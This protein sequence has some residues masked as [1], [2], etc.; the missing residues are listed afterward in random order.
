ER[1]GGGG[2]GPRIGIDGQRAPE[3]I[4]E[5]RQAV[6]TRPPIRGARTPARRRASRSPGR[7]TRREI[8]PAGGAVAELRGQRFPPGCQLIGSAGD[9][10]HVGGLRSTP[11]VSP[12]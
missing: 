3:P 9:P 12:L 5:A 7:R 10:R 6:R 11:R 2:W 1:G 8:E 4:E